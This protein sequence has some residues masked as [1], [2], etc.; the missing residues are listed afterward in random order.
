VF[1][2]SLSKKITITNWDRGQMP[3]YHIPGNEAGEIP[4]KTTVK[5]MSVIPSYGKRLINGFDDP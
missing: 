4:F 5:F 3:V 1:Y 2:D